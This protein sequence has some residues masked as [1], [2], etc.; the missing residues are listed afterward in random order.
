MH[1]KIEC[2]CCSI[3]TY[4]LQIM[5]RHRNDKLYDI[6]ERQQGLFTARQAVAAG[7][8]HRNHSYHVEAGNWIREHR[9]IYR[10]KSFPYSPSSELVLWYLWSCNKGGEP[11]GVFSHETALEI[12]ELSDLAPAKIYMTVPPKFRR[13]IA[14]PEVLIL[15]KNELRQDDW[16][17]VGGYRV[18]TPT[19]TLYD[20]IFSNISRE[21]VCQAIDEGMSR[22]LYPRKELE[23]YGILS[24][25]KELMKKYAG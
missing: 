1:A 7:F 5:K 13:E 23:K 16:R 4:L 6:A 17:E 9:G 14:T 15:H 2:V 18:T 24:M 22:G 20:V 8:D 3:F 11:Q 25:S 12:Y 21:F 10:L 19:R